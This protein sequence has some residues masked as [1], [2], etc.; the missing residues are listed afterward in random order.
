MNCR[1]IKDLLSAYIDGQLNGAE[2]RRVEQHLASCDDC[3]EELAMLRAA[4]AMVADLPEQELPDGFRAG[5]RARLATAQAAST[6]RAAEE[7]APVSYGW[8]DRT[9]RAMRRPVWRGAMATAASLL[10]VFVLVGQLLPGWDGN[11]W[12][13]TEVGGSIGLSGRAPSPAPPPGPNESPGG[14][15]PLA[16]PGIAT[17]AD[18]DRSAT[19]PPAP[20]GLVSGDGSQVI[21]QASLNI[22]VEDFVIAE[23]KVLPIVDAAGGYI[24]SSSVSL[25]AKVKH[26]WWRIRVPQSKLSDTIT[27]LEELGELTYKEMSSEDVSGVV[28]DLEARISNLRRQEL[29]LGELLSEART[30]DEILRVENELNRIRYQ[31]EAA[32]GQLKWYRERVAMATIYLQLSEPT[33]EVEPVGTGIDLLDRLIKAFVNSWHGIFRFLESFAIFLASLAPVIL[34]VAALWWGYRQVRRARSGG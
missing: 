15:G 17:D 1:K 29:R 6:A 18:P 31:I 9:R 5:L 20:G 24:E 28:I 26:G 33:A 12:R 27:K 16:P 8:F 32:E 23:R 13:L 14:K 4:V 19:A 25:D 7:R 11:I 2:R 21:R 30:L 3:S 22:K 10:L 34:V